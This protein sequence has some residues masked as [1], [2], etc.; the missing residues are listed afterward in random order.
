MGKYC[1]YGVAA[2][3]V[4]TDLSFRNQGASNLA[5]GRFRNRA[6]ELVLHVARG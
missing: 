5:L 6:E 2:E 1:R 3:G 4:N